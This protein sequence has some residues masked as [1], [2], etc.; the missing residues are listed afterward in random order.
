MRY[1][2][3]ILAEPGATVVWYRNELVSG[4]G[5]FLVMGIP[6]VHMRLPGWENRVWGDLIRFGPPSTSLEVWGH[7]IPHLKALDE[8]E[9]P[10]HF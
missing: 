9:R 2:A 7:V 10:N 1:R 5:L 4:T 3:K 6:R 8:A